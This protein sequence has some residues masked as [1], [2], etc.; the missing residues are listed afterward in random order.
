M[1]RSSTEV[2]SSAER[3]YFEAICPAKRHLQARPCFV[4]QVELF[5]MHVNLVQNTMS[6]YLRGSKNPLTVIFVGAIP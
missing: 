2:G 3:W 4:Q 6:G 5:K 1:E